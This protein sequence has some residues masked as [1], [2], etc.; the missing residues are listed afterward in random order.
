MAVH[1]TE[2]SRFYARPDGIGYHFID[3]YV[4]SRNS[5]SNGVYPLVLLFRLLY[6][7]LS[8]EECSAVTWH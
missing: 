7:I 2:L 4:C 6:I 8:F 5:Q 1:T 3:R